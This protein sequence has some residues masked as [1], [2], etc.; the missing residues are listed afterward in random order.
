MS[1][2]Q[3]AADDEYEDFS[4]IADLPHR[5]VLTCYRGGWTSNIELGPTT[6]ASSRP[7]NECRIVNFSAAA[8]EDNPIHR[9][10]RHLQVKELAPSDMRLMEQSPLRRI[11]WIGSRSVQKKKVFHLLQTTRQ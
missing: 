11:R 8:R 5:D 9:S 4:C 1:T 3:C 7:V 6:S 10:K 2:E